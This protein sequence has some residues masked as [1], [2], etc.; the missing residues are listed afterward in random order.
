MSHNPKGISF[1]LSRSQQIDEDEYEEAVED[2]QE[3][4]NKGKG[5]K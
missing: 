5:K 1:L 4:K 2:L 3:F